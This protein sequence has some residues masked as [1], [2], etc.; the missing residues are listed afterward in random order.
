MTNEIMI[1][2]AKAENNIGV[3]EILYQFY[4]EKKHE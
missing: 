3:F 2:V 4:F 1:S